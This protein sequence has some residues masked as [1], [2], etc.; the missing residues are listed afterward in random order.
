V[1]RDKT[2]IKHFSD[3][4]LDAVVEGSLSLRV[5][6]ELKMRLARFE[7]GM[8]MEEKEWRKSGKLRRSAD[9]WQKYWNNEVEEAAKVCN[10][11]LGYVAEIALRLS[12]E[13]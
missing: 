1:G 4:E 12:K 5:E 11:D 3:E 8:A 9:D 6:A 2:N 10:V 13:T 7:L